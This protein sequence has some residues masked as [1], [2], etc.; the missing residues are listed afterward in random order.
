MLLFASL[1]LIQY[2]FKRVLEE[3]NIQVLTFLYGS[4]ICVPGGRFP[5]GEREERKDTVQ[6][7]PAASSLRSCRVSAKKG[8][9]L[10]RTR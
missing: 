10:F 2:I 4:L 8:E 7:F 3:F 1:E 5:A 6:S 9:L